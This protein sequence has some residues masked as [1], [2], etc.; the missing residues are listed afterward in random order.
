MLILECI[1]KEKKNAGDQ[2]SWAIAHFQFYVA[3]L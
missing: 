1:E 2:M 3:T